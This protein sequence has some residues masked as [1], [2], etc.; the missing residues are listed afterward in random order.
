MPK[1]KWNGKHPK[2]GKSQVCLST[3]EGKGK[4]KKVKFSDGATST[5]EESGA[6]RVD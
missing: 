5:I 3:G 2:T 4:N 6:K 1:K